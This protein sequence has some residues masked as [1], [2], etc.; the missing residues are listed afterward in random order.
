MPCAHSLLQSSCCIECFVAGGL[1]CFGLM[2]LINL[3]HSW[4][5]L[6]LKNWNPGYKLEPWLA[7]KI[8]ASK[9]TSPLKLFSAPPLAANPATQPRHLQGQG[10]WL[11]PRC[12]FWLAPGLGC[13]VRCQRALLRGKSTKI[14]DNNDVKNTKERQSSCSARCFLMRPSLMRRRSSRLL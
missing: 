6:S 11:W 3:H 2:L 7:G 8:F 13:H 1:H 9:I 14:F 10:V 5:Y 4:H 12:L